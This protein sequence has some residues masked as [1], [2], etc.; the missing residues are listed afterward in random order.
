[1]SVSSMASLFLPKSLSSTK[2]GS[3]ENSRVKFNEDAGYTTHKKS[4]SN[5]DVGRGDN[6]ILKNG[7]KSPK[8]TI[9]S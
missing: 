8:F 3:L 2:V 5:G 9:K 4:K 7:R 6:H 1:M